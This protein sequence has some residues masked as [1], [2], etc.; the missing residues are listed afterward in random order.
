L[1]HTLA[2]FL[3][4]GACCGCGGGASVDAGLDAPPEV[5]ARFV[6]PPRFNSLTSGWI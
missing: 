4:L 1:A 5:D 3:A 6:D 2:S